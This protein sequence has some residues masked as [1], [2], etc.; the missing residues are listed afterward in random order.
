MN[1]RLPL[2]AAGL[3]GATGVAA[4]AFGAHALRAFLLDRGTAEVWQTGVHYQLVHALALLGLAGWLRAER[5]PAALARAGWAA[6][7]W[8]VGG[9]L[10]SGSLYLLAAGAPNWVGPVTPLGGL[11][12][13]AGW[14]LLITAAWA[15]GASPD[16][17]A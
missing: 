2:V 5:S 8:I 9:L 4:G 10:F 3:F 14:V 7:C 6:R 12:L 16:R 17:A 13:L 1:H 11:A 15:S